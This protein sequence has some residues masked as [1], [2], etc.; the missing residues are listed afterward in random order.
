V[1]LTEKKLTT[2]PKFEKNK[3]EIKSR[4]MEKSFKRQLKTW[5]QSK[6]E[7]SSIRINE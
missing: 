2:D 6:R 4:L 7:E 5:L 1:K 3:E